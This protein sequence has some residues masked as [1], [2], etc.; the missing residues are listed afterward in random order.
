MLTIV[1]A[2]VAAI[3]A[4]IALIQSRGTALLGWACLLLALIFILPKVG[5]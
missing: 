4:A 5:L 2:L 1:L 3:L